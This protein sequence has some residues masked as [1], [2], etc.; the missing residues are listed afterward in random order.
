[1][2]DIRHAGEGGQEGAGAPPAL[3]FG[4]QKCPFSMQ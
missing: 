3:Q 2:V 1:M 4:E